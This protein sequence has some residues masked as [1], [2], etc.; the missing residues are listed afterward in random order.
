MI[1]NQ[2]FSNQH[3]R[4]SSTSSN[5]SSLSDFADSL[6]PQNSNSNLN[7]FT[8]NSITFNQNTMEPQSSLN[9]INSSSSSLPY[10]SY[11]TTLSRKS[12]ISGSDTSESHHSVH[13]NSSYTSGG[14]GVTKRVLSTRQARSDASPYSRD[15]QS[16]SSQ[17]GPSN[18][19]K[20]VDE[21]AHLFH[22]RMEYNSSNEGSQ[23]GEDYEE[24]EEEGEYSGRSSRSSN[25]DW[26]VYIPGGGEKLSKQLDGIEGESF[27]G[28]HGPQTMM[29]SGRDPQEVVAVLDQLASDVSSAHSGTARDKA[30]STF[31]QSW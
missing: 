9:Q 1:S 8:S 28:P 4:N 26:D 31:L 3:S 12:S 25:D 11:N 14:G 16:S 5:Y 19:E 18:S 23:Y 2:S 29:H 13:S 17:A 22:N 24:D 6:Q 7:S 20:S 10:P 15:Y 27:S 21:L 30:R